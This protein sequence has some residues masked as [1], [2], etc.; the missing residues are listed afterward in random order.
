M[1]SIS[2][3]VFDPAGSVVIDADA[4]DSD[5]E[6][7][8]RRLTRSPT[9]NGGVYHD[10]RGFADGDRTLIFKP[11]DLSLAAKDTLV[12]LVRTYALVSVATSEGVFTGSLSF[13]GGASPVVQILI[14]EKLT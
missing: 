3:L 12:Y 5:T 7:V 10:D 11:V 14:K 6:T 1:V 2:S 8:A 13:K 9:L 4:A